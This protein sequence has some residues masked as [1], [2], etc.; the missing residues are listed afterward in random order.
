MDNIGIRTEQLFGEGYRN[1]AEVMA[2]EV[3]ILGNTDIL[4]TLSSTIFK[5]TKKHTANYISNAKKN[6]PLR[7]KA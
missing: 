3:F 6:L 5:G 7:V 2:H 4:D 1:V